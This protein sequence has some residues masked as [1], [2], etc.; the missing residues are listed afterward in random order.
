MKG[1]WEIWGKSDSLSMRKKRRKIAA[2]V[3][4]EGK[5]KKS[6][7]LYEDKQLPF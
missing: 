6:R 1:D 4:M 7:C 2:S 3:E 5:T